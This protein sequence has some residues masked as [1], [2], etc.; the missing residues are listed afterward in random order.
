MFKAIVDVM[1]M[2]L[3]RFGWVALMLYIFGKMV[4]DMV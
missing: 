2:M 1:L 4:I 3:I